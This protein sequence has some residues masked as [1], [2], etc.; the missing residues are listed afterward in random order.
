MK[1]YKC[2]QKLW[3][4]DLRP[5]PS[6]FDIWA[7]SVAQA[8][9]YLEQGNI[10]FIS[11]DNDLAEEEEGHHLASWIE[12]KAFNGDLPPLDWQVHSANP[13]GARSISQAMQNAERFWSEK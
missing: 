11:F 9:D 10:D 4:D 3:L 13:I 7:K 6:D 2:A 12:E 1:I 8:K 5:M